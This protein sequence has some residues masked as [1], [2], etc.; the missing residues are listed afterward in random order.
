MWIHI[1]YIPQ[2]FKLVSISVPCIGVENVVWYE[3]MY[4]E[5]S[6]IKIII[7]VILTWTISLHVLSVLVIIC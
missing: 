1:V 3:C 7:Y 6:I 5:I 2:G 4:I